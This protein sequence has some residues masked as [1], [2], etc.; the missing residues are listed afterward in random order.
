MKKHNL[1]GQ[2]II[3]LT[4]T[5]TLAETPKYFWADSQTSV[6]I[7]GEVM[8]TQQLIEEQL[9][10][11]FQELKQKQRFETPAYHFEVLKTLSVNKTILHVVKVRVKTLAAFLKGQLIYVTYSDD[12]KLVE[13]T[14]PIVARL[15]DKK[16]HTIRVDVIY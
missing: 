12:G 6:S 15:S 8:G 11:N 16:F 5:T 7:V 14:G 13:Y 4:T 3:A 10:K 2:L 1:V 9:S